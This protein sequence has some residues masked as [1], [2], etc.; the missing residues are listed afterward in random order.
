MEGVVRE[1]LDL[2]VPA[3]PGLQHHSCNGCNA[4]KSELQNVKL[5]VKELK[6]QIAYSNEPT[7]TTGQPSWGFLGVSQVLSP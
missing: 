6:R 3:S 4:L 7:T 2:D 1:V 5:E